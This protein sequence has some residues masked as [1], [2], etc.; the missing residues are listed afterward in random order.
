MAKTYILLFPEQ[1]D[2]QLSLFVR[3][4]CGYNGKNAIVPFYLQISE[5]DSEVYSM[6]KTKEQNYR[7]MRIALHSLRLELSIDLQFKTA[8]RGAAVV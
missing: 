1:L 5:R 3:E 2:R 4:S 6:A 8:H 7:N